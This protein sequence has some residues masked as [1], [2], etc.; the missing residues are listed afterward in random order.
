MKVIIDRASCT[1][2]RLCSETCP[3]LFEENEKDTFSQIVKKFRHDGNIA[4]GVPPEELEDCA[5]EA[6]DLCPVQII[7][8]EE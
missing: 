3:L 8:I 2:C 1:S 4:V 5:R 6:A 7:T